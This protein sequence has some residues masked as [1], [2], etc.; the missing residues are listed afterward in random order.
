MALYDPEPRF[1]IYLAEKF[2][3]SSPIPDVLHSNVL[4]FL[5]TTS[6]FVDAIHRKTEQFKGFGDPTSLIGKDVICF[7]AIDHNNIGSVGKLMGLFTILKGKRVYGPFKR[8]DLYTKEQLNVVTKVIKDDWF[9]KSFGCK[10]YVGIDNDGTFVERNSFGSPD[11]NCVAVCVA[12]RLSKY[13]RSFDQALDFCLYSSSEIAPLIVFMASVIRDGNNYRSW[14]NL[15]LSLIRHKRVM[16]Y[17]F[18]VMKKLKPYYMERFK[19]Y[20]RRGVEAKIVSYNQIR[21]IMH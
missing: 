1:N 10:T 13:S 6:C 20:V 18:R 14:R 21:S 9:S 5:N 15:P 2:L 17:L 3:K 4:G 8:A 11:K 12:G 16:F 7:S 19:N